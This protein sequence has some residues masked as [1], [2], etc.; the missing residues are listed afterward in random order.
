MDYRYQPTVSMNW[1]KYSLISAPAIAVMRRHMQIRPE[2]IITVIW[3]KRGHDTVWLRVLIRSRISVHIC[4]EGKSLLFGNLFTLLPF[5]AAIIFSQP[6]PSSAV[7]YLLK[8][9]IPFQPSLQIWTRFHPSHCEALSAWSSLNSGG[10]SKPSLCLL[11][12]RPLIPQPSFTLS[13][14]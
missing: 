3:Q 7:F 4:K 6:S 10:I 11:I 13:H 5:P 9:K 8:L 2:D 1:I 12:C 14:T